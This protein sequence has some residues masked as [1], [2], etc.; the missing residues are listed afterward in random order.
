VIQNYLYFPNPDPLYAMLGT[1]IGNT[2]KGSPVWLI[3]VGP[4]ACGKTQLLQ[5][6]EKLPGIIPLDSVTGDAALLSGTKRKEISEDATGGLLREL[7]PRGLLL[8]EDFTTVLSWPQDQIKRFLGT[9]RRI[10]DGKWDRPVGSDGG[11]RLGWEGRAGFLSGSTDA[12]DDH[13]MHN[14]EMGER[15]LYYRYPETEGWAESNKAMEHP[16]REERT[17]QIQLAILEF[18]M[19][20]GF[21]WD[22]DALPEPMSRLET[23]RIIAVSQIAAK[24]N[25]AVVRDPKTREITS[26]KQAH[27]PTRIVGELS[28]MYRGMERIGVSEAERWRILRKIGLDS[29]PQAKGDALRMAAAE[30]RHGTTLGDVARELRMSYS[31][32]KRAVEELK[33]HGL[34]HE[35]KVQGSAEGRWRLSDW[36]EERFQTGWGLHEQQ[37]HQRFE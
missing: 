22:D 21:D 13:L 19:E 7:G 3:L 36:G 35:D 16:D 23:E 11:Q 8:M 28:Q 34:V 33:S 32:A 25:S 26:V 29:M 27:A 20:I 18:A 37:L 14:S 5:G 1:L 10:Y 4:S 24:G 17:E 31:G 15:C 30:G 9:L 12:I 6:I 2:L